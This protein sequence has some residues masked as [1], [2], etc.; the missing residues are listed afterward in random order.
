YEDKEAKRRSRRATALVVLLVLGVVAGAIRWHRL[1]TGRYFWQPA[2][3]ATEQVPATAPA[4]PAEP[5][6]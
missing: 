4:A 6:S 5:K 2:P 1:K 3:A